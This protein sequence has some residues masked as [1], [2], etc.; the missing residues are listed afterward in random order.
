MSD[1]KPDAK[2]E[3]PKE[4]KEGEATEAPKKK[5]P[6]KAIGIV[7]V[8]MIAEAAAVMFVLG[9]SKPKEAAAEVDPAHLVDDESEKTQE[10]ELLA[11]KFQNLTTGRAWVWDVQIV[12]QVKNKN[13]DR[14]AEVFEQ[15]AAEIKEGLGQIV[16]RAR[17]TQLIEPE[18]QSLIRQIGAFLDKTEGISH[19]GKSAIERVFIPKCRGFPSDT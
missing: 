10:I 5:L 3:A 16:G 1:K 18:K 4:K 7:A 19:D 11:E 17:H 15:R 9:S 8:L 2:A 12:V 14:V 6:I 13:A